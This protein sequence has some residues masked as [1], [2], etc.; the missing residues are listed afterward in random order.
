MSINTVQLS[1]CLLVGAIAGPVSAQLAPVPDERAPAG[2]EPQVVIIQYDSGRVVVVRRV[3]GELLV[4]EPGI[5]VAANLGR[6]LEAAEPALPQT[7]QGKPTTSD[8]LAAQEAPLFYSPQ[9]YPP[10]SRLYPAITHQERAVERRKQDAVELR[11]QVRARRQE[12]GTAGTTNSAGQVYP[13]A[14]ADGQQSQYD[15]GAYHEMGGR[16]YD[17][18]Y[19][20][21]GEF[22][23][24]R[25][26]ELAA[27]AELS[28]LS[29][30]ALLAEGLSFFRG[31]RY[32]QAARSFIAATEKD[33]GDAASRL[34][35]AQCLMAS[36]L[37]SQARAHVR[38]AFELA[39][40]LIYRPLNHR[41]NYAFP[42][43][44]DRHLEALWR[45]VRAHP[46]DDDATILLAYEQFFGDR[47]KDSTAAM[48][49]VKANAKSDG[50]ARRLWKAAQPMLGDRTA[51]RR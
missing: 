27:R 7:R 24:Y 21:G 13:S 43:D 15:G 5:D 17:S 47:P 23:Y 38:R 9:W 44:F 33:Q 32:A 2:D 11:E 22:E 46:R 25:Q 51:N 41:E 10:D 18:L 12:Q 4:V 19:R 48:R 35:A 39:P 16:R 40:Q 50:F 1:I 49:R 29:Y 36:G 26:Q 34:H 6:Y 31:R 28:L 42:T 3:N 8:D 37:Y 45:Y 14:A 30:D 20:L